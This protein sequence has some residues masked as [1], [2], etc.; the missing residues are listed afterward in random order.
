MISSRLAEP[1]TAEFMSTRLVEFWEKHEDSVGLAVERSQLQHKVDEW[2]NYLQV[3]AD[4]P[5]IKNGARDSF[6]KSNEKVQQGAA[7]FECE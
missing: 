2:A 1:E 4:R 3:M 6:E 7:G 5:A